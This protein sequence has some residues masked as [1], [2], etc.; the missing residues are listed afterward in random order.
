MGQLA[1]PLQEGSDKG[2]VLLSPHWGIRKEIQVVFDGKVLGTLERLTVRG[3][4]FSVSGGGT[5]A[6]FRRFWGID[7]RHDGALLPNSSTHPP[8][9]MKAAGI[10]LGILGVWYF[11]V[12]VLTFLLGSDS[13]PLLSEAFLPYAFGG[14]LLCL[15]LGHVVYW[16]QNRLALL[17]GALFYTF[18]PSILLF[19]GE[20]HFV[21]AK[22]L[23]IVFLWRPFLTRK[24]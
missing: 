16:H 3:N 22:I 15:G 8:R 17:V 5:V 6:V 18:E 12:S 1:F 13:G 20:S 11:M 19:E 24:S 9:M 21:V 2:V 10:S 4:S 14:A 7:V 23:L